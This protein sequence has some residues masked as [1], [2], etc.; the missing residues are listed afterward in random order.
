[1]SYSGKKTPLQLNAE[2]QL[3]NKTGFN[4]NPAAAALQGVWKAA[5][6][7][8]TPTALSY[9]QGTVTSSTVLQKLT[10]ALPNFYSQVP[11][12]LCVQVWRNLLRI[13]RPYDNT[14][15]NCPAL[16]NSM[17]D[18]FQTTFAGFGNFETNKLTDQYFNTT[19]IVGLGLTAP[20]YP[21][22][23]YPGNGQY[24]YVWNNWSSLSDA[25]GYPTDCT[26]T[27][28]S[29]YTD[30]AQ[31]YHPYAWIT[32]WPGVNPWQAKTGGDPQQAYDPVGDA[33][34]Y[35][36]AYFPRPDLRVRDQ[37]LI[38]YDEYFRFGFIGT[39]ARQAYYEFWTDYLTRRTNQYQEFLNSIQQYTGFQRSANRNVA[40]AN[41]AKTFIKGNYSNIND[42][43]TSDISGVSLALKDFGNDLIKLG[44]GLSLN[45]IQVFGLPSKLLLT[46]QSAGALTES[47]R[48]ALL[49]SDLNLSE[50]NNILLPTYI[51]TAEQETKVWNAFKLITGQDLEN[52]KIIIN[53]TTVGLVTLQDL[54]NPQKMFP[55]SY[56]SLT[57]PKYNIETLSNKNYDFIYIGGGV[58]T[59]IHNWGGYLTGILPSD[60]AIACGAFMAAM[61]Q[62]KNIQQM[63]IEKFS[64]VVANLEATGKELDLIS[65]ASGTPAN[66]QLLDS[67]TGSIALGSGKAGKYRFCDFLGAMSGQPY[68]Q[69]YNKVVELIKQLQTPTLES[70]YQD[71]YNYSVSGVY[72]STDIQNLIDAANAEI[73]AIQ[74]ANPAGVAELNT[75]WNKIGKQLTYEQRAIPLAIK[76]SRNVYTS[77][78]RADIDAF[79]RS[80]EDYALA[81]EECET[82]PILESI[83]DTG[84]VGG[85]SLLASMRE[86]RNAR[87]LINTGGE[88][89]NN[90]PDDIIA[91]VATAEIS[92][93]S[94]TNITVEGEWSG[95]DCCDPPV[96]TVLPQ[97]GVFGTGNITVTAINQATD[98]TFTV[99][100]I[101]YPAITQV[102]K[103]W[104]SSF[105]AVSTA[106]VSGG[107][108]I[109]TVAGAC[110]KENASYSFV[111]PPL[112]AGSG[113]TATAVLDETGT[114]QRIDVDNPGK[115]YT[116]PPTVYFTAPPQP[117]RLGNAEVPGSFAGSPYTG[118]DPVPDNLISTADSSYTV[119]EAVDQVTV[120]N[121]DCW[122]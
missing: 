85:Q 52:I 53:C 89:D 74:T 42:L 35:A 105:G 103:G 63:T 7:Y 18:T 62:I 20:V 10:A 102:E 16:G 8:N 54:L 36:A 67:Q 72:T 106:T 28:F 26:Q 13:G 32:G 110:F 99:P 96:V 113:A 79:I 120:C 38:E 51:P 60:L 81:T 69:Y 49:Y 46:L 87:R 90:I 92:G 58:N 116:V 111:S 109:I 47:L 119:A 94:V 37:D 83:F 65:S 1:M 97:T 23:G 76:Q 118:Q 75:W 48:A 45:S 34:T 71:L 40:T 43:T 39:V 112:P 9:T 31:Y 98:C 55:S 50:L 59:R 73:L 57:V 2:S 121:C 114:I 100:M 84:T 93:G 11:G 122:K 68:I 17:P 6:P 29:P 95:Y 25:P 30:T 104:I 4:L 64:Q 108:Y 44:K 3:G 78:S 33:D 115:G 66:V 22:D 117:T 61:C 19:T 12:T 41:N 80:I 86:A 91:P 15:V 77:A 24:S 5:T 82:A 14:A 27:V 101:D 70:I 21:P 56:Q 107:D 88:L